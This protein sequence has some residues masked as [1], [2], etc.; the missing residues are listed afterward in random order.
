MPSWMESEASRW[1]SHSMWQSVCG[2]AA[3]T[4]SPAMKN[5]IET[6]P[7]YVELELNDDVVGL[8]KK[9][10]ESLRFFDRR[11]PASFLDTA[12]GVEAFCGYQPRIE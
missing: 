11:R 10:A 5:K 6:D 3:C 7:G 9:L 1:G 2:L 12:G 8:L 4:C